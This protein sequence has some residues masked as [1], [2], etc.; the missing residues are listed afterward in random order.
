MGKSLLVL[1]VFTSILLPMVYAVTFIGPVNYIATHGGI[2]HF[3]QTFTAQSLTYSKGLNF[4]TALFWGGT[5]RGNL[6]FDADSGVNLTVTSILSNRI[7]YTVETLSG[8][9]VQ[10][11]VHY[12]RSVGLYPASAPNEVTGGTWTYNQGTQV[13]TVT[14]SG[15]P[16]TVTIEYYGATVS[17][18]LFDAANILVALLPLMIIAVVISDVKEGVFG[19]GTAGK[20]LLLIVV[21]TVLAWIIRGWGY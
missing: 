18:P 6:G 9:P 1:I 7:T 4:F 17:P 14:T 19:M 5:L 12:R 10:T 15:S 20:S 16:V 21:I 2:V 8:T 3:S 13:I 11:Y